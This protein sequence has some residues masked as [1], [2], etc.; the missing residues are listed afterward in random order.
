MTVPVVGTIKFETGDALRAD[1]NILNPA[2]ELLSKT[3]GVLG[4]VIYGL[5][6]P[7]TLMLLQS[8]HRP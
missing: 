7:I 5:A 8:L 3:H 2:L 6:T 4:C 1:P